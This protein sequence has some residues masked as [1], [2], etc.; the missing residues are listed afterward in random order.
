MIIKSLETTAGFKAGDASF[1]KELLHPAKESLAIGYS[2]ARAEVGPGAKTLPHRL[3]SAEVYFILEGRGRMHI[4]G[5]Q[6]EV[7]AGIGRLH[8]AGLDPVHRE[9]RGGGSR[10]PLHRRPGLAGL[11]RRGPVGTRSR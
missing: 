5:E 2:L 1:L 9:H 6:A 8:P 4:G 3:K 11:G 7:G 10:L